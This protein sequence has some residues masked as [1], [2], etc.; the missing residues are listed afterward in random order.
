MHLDAVTVDFVKKPVLKMPLNSQEI[1]NWQ[2]LP[3][4]RGFGTLNI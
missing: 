3:G 4:K 1:M 2:F